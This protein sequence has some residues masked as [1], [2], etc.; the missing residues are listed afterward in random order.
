MLTAD[1]LSEIVRLVVASVRPPTKVDNPL[2]LA[3]L[4]QYISQG[5]TV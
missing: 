4:E 3:R 1:Q 5:F 2:A